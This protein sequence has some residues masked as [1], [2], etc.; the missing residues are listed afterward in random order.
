MKK[1]L[2]CLVIAVALLLSGCCISHRWTEADC[3]TP[4]TCAKCE[5][6]EGDALGHSWAEATCVAP[7]TCTVCAVTEGEALGHSWEDATCYVPKTCS[8]CAETEGEILEHNLEWRPSTTDIEKMVGSCTFC[9][10]EFKEEMDWFKAAPGLI[11]GN[12]KAVAME[13]EDQAYSMKE[14]MNLEVRKD[15]TATLDM[16]GEIYEMKSEFIQVDTYEGETE[17]RLLYRMTLDDESSV[18]MAILYDFD[19]E[20]AVYLIFDEYIIVFDRT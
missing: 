11:V 6:T 7:K 18:I 19:P 5:E 20:Y 9:F 16:F 2:F 4:K 13:K 8:V 15:G 14:G 3:V 10:Q 1:M 12:W 17:V